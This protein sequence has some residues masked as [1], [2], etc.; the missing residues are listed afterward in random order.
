VQW[1]VAHVWWTSAALATL[2]VVFPQGRDLSRSLAWVIF[3]SALVL[4]W[5][6][7]AA[8]MRRIYLQNRAYV[9]PSDSRNVPAGTPSVDNQAVGAV[10]N[11]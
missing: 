7:G 6:P 1:L 11:A 5:V 2:L 8:R 9:R 10:A 4:L 3:G